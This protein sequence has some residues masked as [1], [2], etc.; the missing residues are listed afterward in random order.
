MLVRRRGGRSGLSSPAGSASQTTV[1]GNLVSV[2]VNGFTAFGA[3]VVPAVDAG[4]AACRADSDC[5][6]GQ[7]CTNGTCVTSAI[8][9]AG[10]GPCRLDSD[11]VSGQ[12]CVS[13]TCT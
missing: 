11:C 13:G 7:M 10:P 12:V 9:D 8:T 5:A 2:A 4:P 6:T 1:S 3:L